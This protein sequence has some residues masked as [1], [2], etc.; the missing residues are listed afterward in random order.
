VGEEEWGM[1]VTHVIYLEGE[2]TPRVE[3]EVLGRAG[4]ECVRIYGRKRDGKGGEGGM[5]YDGT[6][7][8]Q[9]LEAIIGS[10]KRGVVDRSRRNTLG[11]SGVAG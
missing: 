4:V 2:G 8:T 9:A 11:I 10:G 7:L 5:V 6:A 3:R 1:Y